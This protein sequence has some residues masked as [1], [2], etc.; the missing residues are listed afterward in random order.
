[1]IIAAIC[2]RGGSKGVPGKNLRTI[3]GKP[4]LAYAID[5][6][7]Q[8]PRVDRIVVS[9]DDPRIADVARSLGAEVPFMRPPELAQDTTPK[10]PVFQH[11]VRE[12]ERQGKR[13]DI[14]A[15]LDAAAPLRTSADLTGA[16]DTLIGSDAD[17][18]IT[19]YEPERNPY[20]NMVEEH[21]GLAVIV[22]RTTSPV[23]RR[24]DAPPVYSLSPAVF[25]MKRDFLLRSSHWSEGRVRLSQMPRER[26]LDIDSELDL[27][28]AEFLLTN[29]GGTS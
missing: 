14:L 28:F 6:A 22:K 20:F 17:V 9:T 21:D 5:C 4:L 7:R 8:S 29:A 1:V 16:L 12:L 19:A 11:L 24:Q 23:T 13:V 27:R 15:D 3:R 26:A 25:A 18:V 10:W 2:A